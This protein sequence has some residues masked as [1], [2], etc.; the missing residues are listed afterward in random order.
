LASTTR[1]LVCVLLFAASPARADDISDAQ[2]E[3]EKAQEDLERGE[4]EAAIGRFNVARSLVKSSSGPYLGLGLAYARMGHCEQAIPYLEEYLRRKKSNPKPEAHTTLAECRSRAVAPTGKI[5]VTSEPS[6]AEV[7]FDEVQGPILGVTPFESQPMAPGRHRVFVAK[8]GYRGASS[9]VVVNAGE[10]ATFTV[11]LVPEA[12]APP[13]PPPQIV[14]VVPQPIITAAPV[15]NAPPPVAAAP[16][17]LVVE[18]GP[19]GASVSVNGSQVAKETRRYEASQA[20]GNLKVLIEKDGYRAM[21]TELVLAPGATEKRTLTLQPL[22]RS[23][24]LGV[25]VG[26]TVV[27]AAAGV[28]AIASYVIA[29]DKP[30]DTSSYNT[31]KNATLALQGIFYGTLA[32]A[33]VGYIVYGVTNRG[34]VADGPPLRAHLDRN[35]TLHF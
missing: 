9:E 20:S 6:G 29:N 16:G 26:F 2:A 33:A 11:A 31:N 32:V 7:R 23:T 17:K 12:A 19:V 15:F 14:R 5:I 1:F 24:W 8:S 28:G 13:P 27:A 21:A 30:R 25:G 22:K 35:L 18:V 3:M 34:R 10:R 4:F